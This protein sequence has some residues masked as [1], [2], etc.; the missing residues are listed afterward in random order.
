MQKKENGILKGSLFLGISAFITKLLGAI[1]RVPLTN[2]IGA[3]GIGVYQMVFP[4]YCVLLD[5]SGA[6]VPSALSFLIS[7]NREN[8][9]Y[10][11]TVLFGSLKLFSVVGVIA[12]LI[13]MS[14]SYPLS[15]AQGNSKAFLGYVF[16]SPAVILVALISCYRGY[17]QGKMNMLP[18][19]VSQIIEQSVK[20][21]VGLLLCK[22]LMPSVEKAVGGATSAV[23]IS[24][25]IALI[26]LIF[27]YKRKQRKVVPFDKAL[28]LKE[29]GRFIKCTAIVTLISVLIPLSQVI[30]SFLIV[31]VLSRYRQDATSLYGLFSGTAQTVISLSVS[32]CYAV[33]TVAI[34]AVSGAKSHDEKL[35]SLKK[36]LFLTLAV[37]LILAVLTYFFSP[38]IVR[39]LFSK[40][41]QEEKT[42]T[43]K[44]IK[45]LSV[46]VVLLSLLQTQNALLIG[47]NKKIYPVI[48]LSIGIIIKIILSVCLLYRPDINIFGSV[49]GV[50]ACYFIACLI[51]F[52]WIIKFGVKN[53][54]KANFNRQNSCR[55]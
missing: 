32:V 12:T 54:S 3:E 4:V 26:Y 49:I 42:L 28:F 14:L 38:L 17:F 34:P 5:L 45:S 24:E 23:T 31:N 1:Y 27:H 25:L 55:E 8:E 30:D 19:S 36:T 48:S 43:I 29:R 39:I 7:K 15:I 18:T 35:N 11:Q 53:A 51:N 47:L 20:L 46:T 9:R 41:L 37:S 10:A 50:I 52:I 21:G 6:G 2:L 40:L 22:L 33:A 13:M 16:L 44:L